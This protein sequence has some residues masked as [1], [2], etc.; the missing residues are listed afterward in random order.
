MADK[1]EKVIVPSLPLEPAGEHGADRGRK[2]VNERRERRP[3]A[4]NKQER[5]PAASP[6]DEDVKDEKDRGKGTVI[7][8]RV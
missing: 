8:I 5:A 7:N 1:I 2:G 3:A 4:A 6:E